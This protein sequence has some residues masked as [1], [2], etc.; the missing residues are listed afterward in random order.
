MP[1]LSAEAVAETM[2]LRNECADRI[3]RDPNEV[4]I[5]HEMPRAPHLDEQQISEADYA[6]ALTYIQIARRLPKV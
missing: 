3:G 2:R 5:I 1:F 4:K 6:R